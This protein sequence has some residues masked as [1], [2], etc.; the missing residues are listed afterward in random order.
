MA[1]QRRHGRRQRG[2]LRPHG[3]TDENISTSFPGLAAARHTVV[4][5]LTATT[6]TAAAGYAV[7]VDGFTAGTTT[8]QGSTQGREY[9]AST[10]ASS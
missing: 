9:N 4:V 3:S 8:T 2:N 6:N 10:G 7:T 5:E 1:S